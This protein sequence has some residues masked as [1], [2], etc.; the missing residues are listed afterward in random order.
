ML[1]VQSRLRAIGYDPGPLDGSAGPLTAA[2]VRQYQQARRLPPTGSADRDLLAR[3]RREAAAAPLPSRT[4]PPP[5]PRNYAT[6]R[7]QQRDEFMDYIDRL[8]RR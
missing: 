2:A 5:P 3:L 1:E 8:I 6:A 7:P 4:Q